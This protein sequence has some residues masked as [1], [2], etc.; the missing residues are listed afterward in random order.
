MSDTTNIKR[1][2]VLSQ[3]WRENMTKNELRKYAKSNIIPVDEFVANIN[4]ELKQVEKFWQAIATQLDLACEQYGFGSKEFKHIVD[5]FKKEYGALTER[6]F[7]D[8]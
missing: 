8:D 4:D 1:A 6:T 2:I 3:T 5:A 7:G